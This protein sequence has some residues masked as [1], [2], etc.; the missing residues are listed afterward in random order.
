[1]QISTMAEIA[2]GTSSPIKYPYQTIPEFLGDSDAGQQRSR[3][4]TYMLH[5]SL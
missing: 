2:G 4:D 1:M 3:L 5:L